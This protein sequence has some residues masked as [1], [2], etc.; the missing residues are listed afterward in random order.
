MTPPRQRSPR[1]RPPLGTPPPGGLPWARAAGPPLGVLAILLVGWEL[2]VV[3]SGV[4]EYLLPSPRRVFT[5]LGDGWQ[6]LGAAAL[7]TAGATLLSFALAAI[8]GVLLGSLLSLSRRVERGVYPL[9]L[10]LQMVPLVAIAPMLSIWFGWGLPSVVAAGVIVAIFPVIASTLSG[11]RSVDEGHRELF[12]VLGASRSATWF[13]LGLPSAIPAIFTGLRIAAG[14]AVIGTIVGE[15]VGAFGGEQAPLGA[16]IT[17]ALKQN[18]TPEVFA[19]ILLAAAVGFAIFGVVHAVSW[20]LLRRWHS[21]A[22]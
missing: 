12:A 20:Q 3:A 2:A 7:R 11:L 16:I 4:G 19:A 9:T 18:R 22:N 1:S 6:R 21:S 17:S 10:M 8:G 5:A 13:K 14:L 15:M